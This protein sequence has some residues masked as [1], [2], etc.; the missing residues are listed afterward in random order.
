M[1]SIKSSLFNGALFTGVS[2]YTVMFVNLIVT[3]ILARL[4]QPEDFGVVALTAVVT[5]F[6]DILANA[7]IGPAIIQNNDLNDEDLPNLFRFSLYIAITLTLFFCCISYPISLFYN[8]YQLVIILLISSIQLFFNTINVVPLSLLLKEKRFKLVARNTMISSILCGSLSIIA[9]ILGLGLYSLLITPV[10]CSIII[11][12]LTIKQNKQII[13]FRTY[14]VSKDSIKK[15]LSFSVYQFSFNCVNFFSR[16]LDK[17]LMG[18]YVGMQ[19]LGYYEKSYRLMTLP[20]STLT[21]V[22]TPVLHP[23]LSEYQDDASTIRNVY[24]KMSIYLF[25]IGTILAP[26]LYFC[27]DEVILFVF[28]P[29][30]S[31]AVPIFKILAISVPFQLVDSLSG[32]ILQSTNKVS[33]LFKSGVF[34]AIVNVFCLVF[35]IV[36][37]SD[38][39]IISVFISVGFILNYFISVYYICEC[40]LNQSIITYFKINIKNFISMGVLSAILMF[41]SFIPSKTVVSFVIKTIV[42]V[43][44]AFCAGIVLNYLQTDSLKL[45]IKRMISLLSR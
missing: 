28:G 27:A 6:F 42:S 33:L 44:Y 43:F 18:K 25:F 16:N 30:W 37:Y 41:I 13:S 8:E 15:I 40:A 29:Q 19:S 2:K 32:S 14:C 12:I 26:Y 22:F 36:V 5:S 45:Y 35:S 17:L 7:G 39:K 20:I 23:V 1:S 21:N 11:F 4:L 3:S 31:P 24:N 34:S 9:A 38:I 10:G